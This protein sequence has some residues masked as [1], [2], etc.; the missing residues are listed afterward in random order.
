[1]MKNVRHQRRLALLA[2]LLLTMAAVPFTAF[3][4]PGHGPNPGDENECD[5]FDGTGPGT[6]GGHHQRPCFFAA[7]IPQRIYDPRI[8][9]YVN[10]ES[11][12]VACDPCGIYVFGSP[13]DEGLCVE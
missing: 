5:F 13:G 9:D 10:V 6:G 2:G 8:D 3:S 1:M 7:E 12:Y 4:G 11:Y